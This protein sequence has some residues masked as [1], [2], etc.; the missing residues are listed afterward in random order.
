MR[1]LDHGRYT[2]AT[3]VDFFNGLF[4]LGTVFEKKKRAVEIYLRIRYIDRVYLDIG[5]E[6]E[7]EYNFSYAGCLVKILTR[8]RKT[9]ETDC[10][11]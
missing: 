1:F 11:L 9:I 6:N 4:K 2:V 5:F 8:I 7:I 10:L 3:H